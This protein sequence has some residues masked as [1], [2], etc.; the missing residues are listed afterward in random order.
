[1]PPDSNN[2]LFHRYQFF[3]AVLCLGAIG[4]NRAHAADT[5]AD[6]NWPQWRGPLGNGI[7]PKA[8]P[9]TH[10]SATSQLKWQTPLPGE[11][12]STPI[13][14]G[15]R[16]FI[17]AAINTGHPGPT[18]GSSAQPPPPGGRRARRGIGFRP[19]PTEALP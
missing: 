15:D 11:G 13:V 19:P 10:W 4:F 14:W 2:R 9:P 3:I 8:D 1:M 5:T 7:A 18:A 12:T 6:E 16:V 17:Q